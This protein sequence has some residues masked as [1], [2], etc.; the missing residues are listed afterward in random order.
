MA[1]KKLERII[2][3][4]FAI[5]IVLS[6]GQLS[7]SSLTAKAAVSQSQIDNLKKQQKEIEQNKQEIQRQIN[8]LQAQKSNSVEEKQMLDEEI[9]LTENE[10]ENI[11]DQI[12]LYDQLITQKEIETQKAQE[13]ED[14]QW[15]KYKDILRIMEENGT[16]TYISVIFQANDFAD[17]LGRIDLVGEIMQYN[18]NVYQKLKADKEATIEAK[19]TLQ[20]AKDDK[21]YEVKTLKDKQAEL[22][23][24][25]EAST[26]L[27][28]QLEAD[29]NEAKAL[30]DQM[31]ASASEIQ[32]EINQK[33]KEL[34]QQQ[35]QSGGS[36]KGSG[37]FTWPVPSCK[38]V[39]SPF[40]NRLHPVYK[41][42]IMHTGADI[43]AARGSNVV[44]ADGGTVI[45]ASYQSGYGNY[46]VISHGDGVTTLYG[47]LS[48][49]LVKVGDGVKK[50]DL[51]AKS[52]STGLVSGPNMHFE[53]SVNGS[54]VNPL[55]YFS[56]YT[57][58]S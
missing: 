5:A 55:K 10:I 53:V 25:L 50:G 23:V 45:K 2:F 8:D 57:I 13:T 3:I 21:E 40:G 38:I 49:S 6:G 46:I 27:L 18:Q 36:I 34:E 35:Q 48:K 43:G 9:R 19:N 7:V 4:M 41:R 58:N 20:S 51:I 30:Y 33:V 32:S 1:K 52:G 22:Q 12:T 29:E 56:G 28:Q 47:H 14:A 17:L 26:Q 54:R 16:I 37:T 15:E 39:T 44:A 42:Y 24:K 11:S 31:N